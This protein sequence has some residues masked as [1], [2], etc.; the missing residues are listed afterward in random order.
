MGRGRRQVPLTALSWTKDRLDH[1]SRR[2]KTDIAWQRSEEKHLRKMA[3]SRGGGDKPMTI[4]SIAVPL[5]SN[6][7]ETSKL[8]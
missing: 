7:S 4:D 3:S 2:S 8:V 6:Y 1:S 5:F